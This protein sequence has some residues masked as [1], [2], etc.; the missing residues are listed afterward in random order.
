MKP[1]TANPNATA[2]V[3]R[4]TP[5]SG[6]KSISSSKPA[7]VNPN[8]TAGAGRGTPLNAGMGRF[9]SSSY[10][11]QANRNGQ[12][13]APKPSSANSAPAHRSVVIPHSGILG[14]AKKPFRDRDPLLDGGKPFAFALG[15]G[16]DGATCWWGML[17]AYV[18]LIN[19]TRYDG[20]ITSITQPPIVKPESYSAAT[21]ENDPY[22]PTEL[23]WWGNVYAYWEFDDSGAISNFD[24]KGPDA[25]DGQDLGELEADLTREV[26]SG[27]FYILIGNVPEDGD[28]EQQISSDIHW[29][30]TIVKGTDTPGSEGDGSTPSDGGSSAIG[31]SKDTA[32][33]PGPN[34]TCVKWYAMESS[35]VLFFDFQEFKVG[36]GTTRIEI[37]P[38]VLFGIERETARTFGSPDVGTAHVTVEGE[39]IIIRSRFPKRMEH[40]TV[41]VMLKATRRGFAGIRNAHATFED[42]VDNECRLNPRMTR[43]QVL[44]ELAIKGITQ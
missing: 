5:I 36:R 40:Q 24:I 30:V 16:E 33:V 15:K 20:K 21:L 11:Q 44:D 14:N 31:S 34:G 27:K 4:G 3:G 2:G 13:A 12:L 37:D 41:Q 23:G 39:E 26:T 35:E 28:I 18:T 7:T 9:I 32:I 6:G 10:A 38:V 43:E 8:A 17:V 25:P 22:E 19:C 29:Y 1:S 42:Y